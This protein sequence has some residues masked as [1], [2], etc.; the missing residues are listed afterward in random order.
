M[1]TRYLP[2]QIGQHSEEVLKEA[3]YTAAEISS[4]FTSGA[5]FQATPSIRP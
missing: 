3:G 4:L 5:A 2:P 1:D